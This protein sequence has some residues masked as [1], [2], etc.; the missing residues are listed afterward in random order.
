MIVPDVNVLVGAFHR[1]AAGH[2]QQ[3]RWLQDQLAGATDIGLIDVVV[4]GFVRIVTHRRIFEDPA[5]TAAALAFLEALRAAPR[6]HQVQSSPV[7]HQ[8]FRHLL[9][10][11]GQLR[12]NL[13]PD[14][15]I[16]AVALAHGAQVATRDRGFARF[17]GLT[18]VD[19][20]IAA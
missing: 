6:A 16:A 7:V 11:D 9:E 2:E 4:V 10:T 15:W 14:T 12:G 8:R 19:P 17:P 18:L 13:V 3:A 1:D 20:M 5:P